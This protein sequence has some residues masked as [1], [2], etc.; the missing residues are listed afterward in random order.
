MKF[1]EINSKTFGLIV[2]KLDDDDYEKV[3]K[4]GLKWSASKDR[5]KF[6]FHKRISKKDKITMHRF[7]M[8]APKGMYVDHINGD[9]LDNTKKN[10]RICSN[11]ANLRNS[12]IRIDNKSG[13]KGVS[14]RK[15][16]KKWVAAIK[17]MY[18]TI[19]LGKFNNKKDA[20][21]ARKNAEKLYWNI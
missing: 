15:D 21:I 19:H 5:G 13:V 18:K 8:D 2:I 11:A 1:L 6:Y 4:L 10:L 20:V 14:F 7:I 12:R 9:T 16:R 17:V 3:A